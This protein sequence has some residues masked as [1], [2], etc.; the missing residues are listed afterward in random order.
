MSEV[1]REAVGVYLSANRQQI[2]DKLDLSSG[3]WADR[4]DMADSAAYVEA[5]RKEWNNR[6]EVDN[7]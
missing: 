7:D 4:K 5:V 2:I 3:L 6:L 1:I